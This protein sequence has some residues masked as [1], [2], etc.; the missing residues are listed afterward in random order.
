M[1]EPSANSAAD[2][3]LAAEWN[4]RLGEAIQARRVAQGLSSA[5]LAALIGVHRTAMWRIEA[6]QRTMSWVLLVQL[7]DALGAPLDALLAEAHIPRVRPA[8]DR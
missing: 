6:G 3:P 7:S 4:A 5:E 8:T 1:V 2:E